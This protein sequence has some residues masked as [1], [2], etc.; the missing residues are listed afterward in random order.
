VTAAEGSCRET[1]EGKNQNVTELCVS[2]LTLLLAALSSPSAAAP[3]LVLVLLAVGGPPLPSVLVSELVEVLVALRF[4][5]GA[6]GA[7]ALVA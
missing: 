1:D 5:L 2:D 7:R 4:G 3:R 6:A